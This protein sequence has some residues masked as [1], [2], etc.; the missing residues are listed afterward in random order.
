MKKIQLSLYIIANIV[1]VSVVLLVLTAIFNPPSAGEAGIG[2]FSSQSFD[3]GWKLQLGDEEKNITLPYAAKNQYKKE[4]KITNTLPDN[5]K[6][7][8]SI[9]V[10]S[11]M[12]DIQL[13]IDGKIRDKYGSN[14][15]NKIGFYTPSAYIVVELTKQDAGKE[16]E[17]NYLV[18]KDKGNIESITLG[19]GNNVWFPV[20]RDNIVEVISA[21][22][23]IVF[24]I[25][26]IVL[27]AFFG[28]RYSIN[29]AV[30]FLG[31][32]I[33]MMGAWLISESRIRQ[34]LFKS[35][36]LS[37]VFCYLSLEILTVFL[38]FYFDEVQKRR[39]HKVY[40]LLESL[41][42]VQLII[43]SILDVTHMYYYHDTLVFSHIWI[44][45]G[46]LTAAG[47][48]IRDFRT[49]RVKK[50]RTSA[51]G[52]SIFLFFGI[53]EIVAYYVLSF[54]S[55]GL[56]ICVGMLILLGATLVQAIQDVLN[57]EKKHRHHVEKS[58]MATIETIASSIDAKDEYTGGH[59]ERVA[60][61]ATV[62]A[63]NIKEEYNLTREDISTIHYIGLMHD[64]G[65]IGVPDSI[66]NKAGRLT[67]DEFA[68]M[69]LHSVIGDGLLK[70]IDTI[71]G[72]SQGV[73]HHH[74][75]YDG[76]GY[77]DGLAGEDIPLVARILC[78]AD[79][80]DAMTSNRIYRR[81]LSDEEVRAEIEKCAG[82]QFDPKLAEIFCQLLDEGKMSPKTIDGLET[83]GDGQL[84]KSS[85]LRFL[86]VDDMVNEE[87]EIS[88]PSFVRM[89]SY[90][91]KLAE[92]QNQRVKI[93]LFESNA[94]EKSQEA[95]LQNKEKLRN[96]LKEKMG[97]SDLSIEYS[98][99]IQLV[100]WFDV[101]DIEVNERLE[102]INKYNN[103]EFEIT[104]EEIGIS[105]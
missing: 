16:I 37:A 83:K 30:L 92:K 96:I 11:D 75:R 70:E 58:T 26:A 48:I 44:V 98:K 90:I 65:K 33:V 93:Y 13:Y 89:I 101:S 5:T 2:E 94:Q 69:K 38:L 36:S 100:V 67:D 50:Y 25:V 81:R 79:C 63:Q 20:I 86:L 51:I 6:D 84:L 27:F 7:G 49:G 91:V 23:M 80:Y 64:I 57:N 42:V 15:L 17:I 52:M 21:I 39:Y 103:K 53:I 77:P 10:R 66:L 4:L 22:V 3:E 35:P 73:R 47:L 95:I 19:M 105:R 82:S 55:L 76:R 32:S 14:N 61:Y 31:Q 88:N 85:L 68:L 62:L 99:N 78:L 54:N 56:Y 8:M 40:I 59:S 9:M 1:L 43:N 34:I 12:E 24:G 46:I 71:K 45:I 28:R 60:F 29:Y 18:K 74:E 104:Y 87:K 97:Y 72:L 102:E 41:S